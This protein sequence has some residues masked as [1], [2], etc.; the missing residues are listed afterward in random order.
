MAKLIR[1]DSGRWYVR[2]ERS[3]KG[4][5]YLQLM[6]AG[7]SGDS[8]RV[9]LPFSW[10]RLDDA[11]I[12]ELARDPD[13]RL[14]ADEHGI[15]WRVSAV[16]PGTHYPFPLQERH[17]VFDSTRT[18]AGITRFPGSRRLG[19]LTSPELREL[20]DRISDL[21]GERQGFRPPAHAL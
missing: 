9:H 15:Q 4:E 13:Q 19:D 17:L 7:S 2:L 8:M 11:E 5:D 6:S 12:A 21:G 3:A 16:G 14:W 18:W 10:R 20:R 1:L